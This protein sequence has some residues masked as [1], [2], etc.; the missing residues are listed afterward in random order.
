M[1][2]RGRVERVRKAACEAPREA[3][4]K[5]LCLSASI[6]LTTV[7]GSADLLAKSCKV[8]A[9]HAEIATVLSREFAIS[10]V[11]VLLLYEWEQISGAR[12]VVG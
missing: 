12:D 7:L 11:K 10:A 8:D 6:E 5:A 9:L 4:R 3:P 2:L 1:A